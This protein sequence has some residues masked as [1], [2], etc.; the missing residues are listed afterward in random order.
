MDRNNGVYS[1]TSEIGGCRATSS[2][3]QRLTEGQVHEVTGATGQ[4]SCAQLQP[5]G[6]Q[7]PRRNR[8]DRKVEA[9]YGLLRE[10][11]YKGIT[12]RGTSLLVN[13]ETLQSTPL[14]AKQ[15]VSTVQSIAYH[16]SGLAVN[17]GDIEQALGVIEGDAPEVQNL[18]AT[19]G[20]TVC[21]DQGQVF[22]LTPVGV[23]EI[24]PSGGYFRPDNIAGAIGYVRLKNGKPPCYQAVFGEVQ[25]QPLLWILG[26]L[27]VPNDSR[28]LVAAWLVTSLHPEADN[29]LLEIVGERRS[30]KSSLQ[31]ILKHLIDPSFEYLVVDTPTTSRQVDVLGRRDN[32]ISLD[33]VDGLSQK[34]QSALLTLLE[35]KL[36]DISTSKK[37]RDTNVMLS[38][39]VLLNSAESVVT[40]S[41]LAD[42]S[43]LVQLPRIENIKENY[44]NQV[45][46]HVNFAFASLVKLLGYVHSRWKS[47]NPTSCPAGMIDFYRI[48]ISVAEAL[49]SSAEDF[50]YQVQASMKRRFA[51]ELSEHPVAV[52]VRDLLGAS[53][54]DCLD[55]PVGQFLVRLNDYRPDHTEDK[56]WPRSPRHLGAK[57]D[58]CGALMEAHGVRVGPPVRK[59][60]HGVFHRRIEKCPSQ[61]YHQ[62]NATPVS[63][64]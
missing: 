32:V 27:N 17:K 25:L 64:I 28:L 40:W 63:S 36:T 60:K 2:T 16:A 54:E 8:K 13:R 48:G 39:P 24:Q 5:Q 29:V 37:E 11:F 15:L 34:V 7:L 19:I 41:D 3:R 31:T 20:L 59:G 49:G 6:S 14:E 47:I 58:S 33:K 23:I 51:L 12:P 55:I 35:G 42:R 53:G 50:D 56:D 46:H 52:A 62:W 21:G 38:H 26:Q 30:G 1:Y 44:F 61:L 10:Y 9:I 43:V 4:V 18:R 57:L 45:S 22:L